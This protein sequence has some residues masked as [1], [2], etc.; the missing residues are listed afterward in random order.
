MTL[1]IRPLSYTVTTKMGGFIFTLSNIYTVKKTLPKIF[2]FYLIKVDRIYFINFGIW[3][4]NLDVGYST[5]V[6]D[7]LV[8][9][10][11]AKLMLH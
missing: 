11:L 2:S 5:N 9:P 3:F 10:F 4:D 8:E 6:L 1:I 7:Y